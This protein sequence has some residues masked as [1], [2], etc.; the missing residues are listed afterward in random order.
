LFR[1]V[2]VGDNVQLNTLNGLA[3]AT[4]KLVSLG[5]TI[6]RDTEQ[7]EIFVPNSVVISSVVIRVAAKKA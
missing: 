7:N 3:T 2:S 5:Y 4:V 1:P 6:L